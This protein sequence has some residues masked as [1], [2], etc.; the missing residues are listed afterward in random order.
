MATAPQKKLHT[1]NEYIAIDARSDMKHEFYRGEVFQM[2]GASRAHN[3][4]RANLTVLIG[5]H[6]RGRECE[7]YDG[8]MRVR[9]GSDMGAYP[10]VVIAC[11]PIEMEQ[12]QGSDTL[13]NPTAMIEILSPST[14]AFDRGRKLGMYQRIP[15]VREYLLVAQDEPRVDHL[16]RMDE[17]QWKLDVHTDLS[18]T[19]RLN[20]IECSLPLAAIYEKVE[21]RLADRPEGDGSARETRN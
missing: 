11:P 14:E 9:V 10:D 3:V 5:G 8:D 6:L 17:Q 2:T 1:F 19:V 15:S 16:V 12:D 4:I 13:L 21:F 20:S 18:A 7:V